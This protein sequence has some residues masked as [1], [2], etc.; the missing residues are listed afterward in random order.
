MTPNISLNLT[1]LDNFS[2]NTI[3]ADSLFSYHLIVLYFK[4]TIY[5]LKGLC[6]TGILVTGTSAKQMKAFLLFFLN[7]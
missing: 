3:L 4:D 5:L 1:L 6:G 2:S 7:T